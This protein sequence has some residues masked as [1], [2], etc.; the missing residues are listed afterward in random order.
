MRRQQGDGRPQ[1]EAL[2]RHPGNAAPGGCLGAS[3]GGRAAWEAED[4]CRGQLALRTPPGREGLAADP[5]SRPQPAA[6]RSG[7]AWAPARPSPLLPELEAAACPPGDL[8]A[9]GGERWAQTRRLAAVPAPLLQ[10]RR[11]C[12]GDAAGRICTS[13]TPQNPSMPEGLG[14][15]PGEP[16]APLYGAGKGSRRRGTARG[17]VS[18]ISLRRCVGGGLLATL[19]PGRPASGHSC[20]ISHP[21]S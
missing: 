4:S 20:C 7:P 9:G 5:V 12:L 13:Q 8:L 10:L 17:Q 3:A 2:D 19:G 18:A 11:G 1:P 6:S 16:P 15:K 21:R 14:K